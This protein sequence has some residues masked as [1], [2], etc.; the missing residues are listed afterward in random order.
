MKKYMYSCNMHKYQCI[1]YYI[2]RTLCKKQS[3]GVNMKFKATDVLLTTN[4]YLPT[5]TI[6]LIDPL[7]V[8][9]ILCVRS[10]T[11]LKRSRDQ[12]L[13]SMRKIQP[14]SCSGLVQHFQQ[15]EQPA[16]HQIPLGTRSLCSSEALFQQEKL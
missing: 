9:Q 16:Q 12:S 11:C 10:L 14:A 6:L 2:M 8:C 15:S 7:Q 3:R 4:F 13:H 1:H 5:K